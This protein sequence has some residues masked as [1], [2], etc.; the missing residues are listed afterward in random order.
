MAGREVVQR[1]RIPLYS[2]TLE[3][4]LHLCHKWPNP[5]AGVLFLEDGPGRF[6]LLFLITPSSL[7]SHSSGYT[8]KAKGCIVL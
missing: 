3:K 4:S 1:A 2:L 6:L 7:P 5:E 8:H